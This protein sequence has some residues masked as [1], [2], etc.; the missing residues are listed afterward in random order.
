MR[1][2]SSATIISPPKAANNQQKGLNCPSG[3]CR[4]ETGLKGFPA[5]AWKANILPFGSVKIS[6]DSFKNN[7]DKIL[8]GDPSVKISKEDAYKLKGE[9]IKNITGPLVLECKDIKAE[10]LKELNQAFAEVKT[11]KDLRTLLDDPRIP[12]TSPIVVTQPAS[13]NFKGYMKAVQKASATKDGSKASAIIENAAQT[14]KGQEVE[15]PEILISASRKEYVQSL[16][17]HIDAGFD[18][19]PLTI[20]YSPLFN[21]RPGEKNEIS[22]K[23][24]NPLYGNKK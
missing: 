8:K 16:I 24:F 5:F 23:L 3:D 20:A 19:E 6:V 18:Y 14:M 10:D 4:V 1:V 11:G 7:V 9:A 17:D 12:E 22:V 13:E 2:T 15:I 21:F